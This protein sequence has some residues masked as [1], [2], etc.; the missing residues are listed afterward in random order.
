MNYLLLLFP[1]VLYTVIFLIEHKK[2]VNTFDKY[3]FILLEI[4]FLSLSCFLILDINNAFLNIPFIRNLRIEFWIS[5]AITMCGTLVSSC[6]VLFIGYYQTKDQRDNYMDDKRIQNKPFL[7]YSFKSEKIIGAEDRWISINGDNY[8]FWMSVQ[9]I[10]LNHLKNF[11]VQIE[12]CDSKINNYFSCDLQQSVIKKDDLKSFELIIG[13]V[14]DETNKN[15]DK[16]I[17]ITIHYDDLLNNSYS[18]KIELSVTVT[19]VYCQECNG[20]RLE[21]NSVKIFD[22]ELVP[23]L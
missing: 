4:V 6:V 9:N 20:R 14:Y 2:F 7:L 3:L 18:Q 15:N 8:S 5:F 1:I 10:G 23:C 13:Y 17:N 11:W 12:D 19:N 22:E 21:I 16:T